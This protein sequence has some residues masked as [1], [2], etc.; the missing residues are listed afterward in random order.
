[1]E[2]VSVFGYGSR[3]AGLRQP[4]CL[5]LKTNTF[6]SNTA[7]L[8]GGGL[9]RH[10][11]RHYHYRQH[12][13]L[14]YCQPGAGVFLLSSNT[15]LA[16]NLIAQ[17]HGGD[18]VL[19]LQQQHHRGRERH[20]RQPWDGPQHARHPRYIQQQHHRRQSG[21]RVFHH[22]ERCE[23]HQQRDCGYHRTLPRRRAYL[24]LNCQ[25]AAQ[26]DHSHQQPRSR[27]R[28]NRRRKHCRGCID[29]HDS[30]RQYNGHPGHRG[31]YGHTPSHPV[32]WQQGGPTAR[33]G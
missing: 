2:D 6:Y 31:E 5:Q 14:E 10:H 16:N 24:R 19:I 22:A 7:A 1:M 11:R 20:P 18:V 32:G 21:Q 13:H 4:R 12:H 33:I 26:H 3:I 29:Q 28:R 9:F 15:V 27:G 8:W 23:A 30:G 25:P 17:N